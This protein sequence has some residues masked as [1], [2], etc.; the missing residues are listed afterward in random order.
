MDSLQR[1]LWQLF[2]KTGSVDAYLSFKEGENGK[3]NFEAGEEFG[4]DKNGGNSH[5]NS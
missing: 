2:E 3:L 1:L 4:T 5:K